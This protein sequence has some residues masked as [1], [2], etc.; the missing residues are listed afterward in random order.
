MLLAGP[1]QEAE[2][3]L[4]AL[5]TMTGKVWYVGERPDLAAIHKLS[6]NAVLVALS[7]TLGDLL[8]IGDAQGL[9]P[10]DV[11]QLFEHFKPAG[12]LPFIA[13]RVAQKGQWPVSF[14]LQMA[15]KDVRLML[16][17]AGGPDGLVVLPAV[18]GAMDQA[19]AQ[20][21]GAKDYSVYAWPRAR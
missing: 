9:K 11:M 19:I 14:E 21:H 5:S 4:P 20:G 10:E 17:S 6:G 1:T 12:A 13:N 15:R 8:A 3:L 2:A 18:A 7:G 16:E